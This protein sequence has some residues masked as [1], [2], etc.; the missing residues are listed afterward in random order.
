IKG[1][2]GTIADPK[3]GASI[4]SAIDYPAT[5]LSFV[6]EFHMT[7]IKSTSYFSGPTSTFTTDFAKLRNP[8]FTRHLSIR[9]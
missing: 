5:T 3:T 4:A 2:P 1:T 7:P 9:R 8:V 6:A